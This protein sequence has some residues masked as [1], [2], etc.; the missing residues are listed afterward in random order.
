[1]LKTTSKYKEKEAIINHVNLLS[2]YIDKDT[3]FVCIGTD[4]VIGDAV[5]PLVGTMLKEKGITNPVYG[6]LEEPMHALNLEK[7][8][9]E[10]KRNHPNAKIVGIDAC[11]GDV[12]D[13]GDVQ[14]RETSIK[15]GRG[16]GKN[17]VEVGEFSLV[18]IVG[19]SHIN[20]IF[21]NSVIR[22]NLVMDISK[23]IVDIVVSSLEKI[24]NETIEE[25]IAI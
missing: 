21:T 6:T 13:I 5:G 25:E 15:P 19:N 20:E 8:F 10:I 11:L 23:Y 22:L 7:R 12:D 14:V 9:Q 2:S 4:R 24:N 17:L 16:V 18:G 3:V 1:M